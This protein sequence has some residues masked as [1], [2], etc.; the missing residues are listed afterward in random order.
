MAMQVMPATSC[1]HGFEVTIEGR[2]V[3]FMSVSP[4]ESSECPARWFGDMRPPWEDYRE[5]NAEAKHT[6]RRK[7]EIGDRREIPPGFRAD[8]VS[9]KQL[10][11]QGFVENT[12]VSSLRRLS[13]ER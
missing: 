3:M 10:V 7:R 9:A 6:T 13:T 4:D 11:S 5:S 12:R 2:S 1:T 8:R